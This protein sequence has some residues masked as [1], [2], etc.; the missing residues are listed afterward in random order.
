MENRFSTGRSWMNVK[1][2]SEKKERERERDR[3][4]EGRGSGVGMLL[5][6]V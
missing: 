4:K 6:C 5:T 2:V 3:K 1:N